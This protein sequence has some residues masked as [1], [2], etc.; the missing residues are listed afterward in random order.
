M[1]DLI[2]G[3]SYNRYILTNIVQGSPPEHCEHLQYYNN[4][5]NNNHRMIIIRHIRLPLLLLYR[6]QLDYVCVLYYTR[7]Q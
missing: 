6:K 5:N 7:G 4:N 3:Y 2:T 1:S